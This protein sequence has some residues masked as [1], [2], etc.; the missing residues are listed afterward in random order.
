MT[1]KEQLDKWVEGESLCPND[2]DECCP[3]FSCCSDVEMPREIKE[4]FR[5][6]Y[7]LGD[8]ETMEK[9]CMSFLGGVIPQVTDKKI[10]VAGTSTPEDPN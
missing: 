4:A 8:H 6:A 7:V 5:N 2:R 10:Y 1:P 9:F 3:D